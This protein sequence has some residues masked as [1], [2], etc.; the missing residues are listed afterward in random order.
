MKALRA[1][2]D[3]VSGTTEFKENQEEVIRD[4]ARIVEMKKGK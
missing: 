4:V 3:K 2:E 1:Y